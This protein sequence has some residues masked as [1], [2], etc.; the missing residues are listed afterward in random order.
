MT[1]GRRSL[2]SEILVAVHV[3]EAK[4]W[5]HKHSQTSFREKKNVFDKS[6]VEIERWA[7]TFKR[8]DSASHEPLFPFLLIKDLPAD[9]AVF[10]FVSL[11]NQP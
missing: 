10:Q 1:H 7:N 6:T 8:N 5:T 2:T 11:Q 9:C 3:T 4:L